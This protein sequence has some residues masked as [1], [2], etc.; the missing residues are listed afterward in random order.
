[1]LVFLHLHAAV[2]N[3]LDAAQATHL[4]VDTQILQS[5]VLWETTVRRHGYQSCLHLHLADGFIQNTL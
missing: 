5:T 4:L 3:A 1:M 2:I